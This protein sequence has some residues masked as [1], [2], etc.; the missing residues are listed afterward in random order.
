M[1]N[2]VQNNGPLHHARLIGINLSYDLVQ[3]PIIKSRCDLFL[4]SLV[5]C[6]KHVVLE[7][8]QRITI[9]MTLS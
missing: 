7:R 4:N 2:G 9:S 6:Y 1:S 3:Y 5:T 8:R